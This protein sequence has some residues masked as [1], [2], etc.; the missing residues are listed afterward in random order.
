MPFGKRDIQVSGHSRRLT[1]DFDRIYSELLEPA[2]RKA[3]CEPFRADSEVSAGDIRTDMFFELVTAD[4]AV[5]DISI[6]NPNVYYELGIRDAACPRGVFIVHG[7]WSAHPP[8]DVAADRSF[9]YNGSLFSVD[10]AAEADPKAFADAVSDL[11]AVF[12]RAIASDSHGTGSPL[13]SHLPGLVPVKWD[14]IETSRSRY[15]GALQHDWE[16]RVRM[17]LELHRPGHIITIAQDA[18]TRIHRTLILS[19]AAR[20][21]IGLCQYS[22]AEDVLKEVLELTPDDTDSQLYLGIVQALRGD[23]QRAEHQ[24]RNMLR[25]H[26]TNS[27]AGAALGYVYRLLWY[28]QWKHDANPR[29]RAK[30][31]FEL[32]RQAIR[33]FN[34]VQRRHTE[35]Y[36]SGYNALLLMEIAAELFPGFQLP[37]PIVDCEELAIVVRYAATSAKQIAEETGDYDN[38]FWSAVALSGLEMLEGNKEAA[39]Q[40]IQDACAVPF[41]TLFYLRLLWERLE[42]LKSLNFKT[43]MVDPMI[44]TVEH[45][46][47]SKI[48]RAKWAKVVVFHGYPVDKPGS[49]AGRFPRSRVTAVENSID[50]VLGEWKVREGDLAICTGSTEA[51]VIFGEKC[52]A[53][54]AKVRLLILEPTPI[55]LA[56]DFSDR[57]ARE[58][59]T[60]SSALVNHPAT[61]VWYHREELGD[62]AEPAYAQGRH[63]RWVLNTARM[64]AENSTEETRVYG[65][66]MSDGSVDVTNPEH[67]SF[68]ISEIRSSN[69]YKGRA[70]TI[71]PGVAAASGNGG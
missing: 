66:V 19:Q 46:M 28:L 57:F 38:L 22:A 2:L 71:N 53:R 68:F 1:V 11:A 58:W 25:Q 37:P 44:A 21:L 7:G 54:G 27:Q 4:F 33:N 15:F 39:V 42:L 69:R 31:S 60:R 52:L 10:G 23:T 18:P 16:E 67:P 62:P 8:F 56:E 9:K 45:A 50:E 24:M 48:S 47:E 70:L 13:Y 51:D 59:A 3:N 61:E 55:Q 43:E 34:D 20:A 64:E 5:A 63:N 12:S 26:E 40:G 30:E 32:L 17:A 6:P 36:F 65:L 14:G 49:A 29:Q 35:Q 41:A